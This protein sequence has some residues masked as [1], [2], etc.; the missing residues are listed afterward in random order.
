MGA[1][2]CSL[3]PTGSQLP[4]PPAP[5]GCH[6]RPCCSPCTRRTIAWR[7]WNTSL[8]FHRPSP[9]PSLGLSMHTRSQLRVGWAEAAHAKHAC[10]LEHVL[11]D[12]S[13][14]HGSTCIGK[15]GPGTHLRAAGGAA[16][17]AAAAPSCSVC[18]LAEAGVHATPARSAPRCASWRP[19]CGPQP[20]GWCK[21]RDGSA[22]HAQRVGCSLEAMRP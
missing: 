15:A 18:R 21:T 4:D 1:P 22:K 2:G 11:T 16:L 12:G 20:D 3:P 10:S 8:R 19:E 14:L 13:A 9:C 5:C 6:K 17:A 7:G